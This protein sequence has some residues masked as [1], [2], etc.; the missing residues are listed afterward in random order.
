MHAHGHTHTQARVCTH[1]GMIVNTFLIQLML[2]ENLT[3]LIIT[4]LIRFFRVNKSSTAL[5]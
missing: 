1:S 3:C 2:P 5:S 4:D